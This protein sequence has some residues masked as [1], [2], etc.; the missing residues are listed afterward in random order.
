MKKINLWSHRD[1]NEKF[2]F[3][4]RRKLYN[5]IQS[6]SEIISNTFYKSPNLT[7]PFEGCVK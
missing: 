6:F 1:K 5:S 7:K 4:L 2:Y 3:Y